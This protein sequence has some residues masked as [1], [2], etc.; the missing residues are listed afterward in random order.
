MDPSNPLH[1]LLPELWALIRA[2]LQT[3]W[4]ARDR[5]ALQ[6]VCKDTHRADPDLILAP[7]WAAL[8]AEARK[9]VGLCEYWRRALNTVAMM[10]EVGKIRL[11]AQDMCGEPTGATC[12]D[13]CEFYWMEP[14]V[15]WHIR[16]RY[17]RLNG[18]TIWKQTPSGPPL[19]GRHRSHHIGHL[20][21]T[22][23]YWRDEQRN[24]P[25]D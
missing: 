21:F 7:R 24:P 13:H 4:E 23:Q 20:F 2:E 3:P 22:M 1:V 18:M 11:F 8:L 12:G 25:K 16:L 6:R 10:K 17:D 14:G 19:T 9:D 15:E 5:V